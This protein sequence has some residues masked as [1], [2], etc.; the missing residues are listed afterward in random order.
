[1]RMRAL[2]G[3]CPF[4]WGRHLGFFLAFALLLFSGEAAFAAVTVNPSILPAGTQG[5]AYDENV[6]GSGGTGPYTFSVTAGAL[7]TGITLNGATGDL[8]GTPS[9]QGVYNF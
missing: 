6:T 2:N 7:P 8:T 3:P 5:V 9:A 4:R 1:M